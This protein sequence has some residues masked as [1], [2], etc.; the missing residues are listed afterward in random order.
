MRLRSR[1]PEDTHRTRQ[2]TPRPTPGRSRAAM[3][4][5]ANSGNEV[6]IATSV[7]PI[8]ASVTPKARATEMEPSISSSAPIG[9]PMTPRIVKPAIFQPGMSG[10][11]SS[12]R[13]PAPPFW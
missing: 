1:K 5:V 13:S 8:T 3:I 7:R 2:G 12:G 9:N 4:V 11:A 10:S 6:P